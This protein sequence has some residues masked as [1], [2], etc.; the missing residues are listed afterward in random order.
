MKNKVI[1]LDSHASTPVD[2]DVLSEML[3]FFTQYYGNGNHKAG[4]KSAAAMEVA[5]NQVSNLIGARP[6]EV[7]FTSGATEAINMA[8]L[9]LAGANKTN[10]KHIITQRTEHAAVLECLDSL[11]E[12]GYRITLLDVDAVGRIDLNELQDV[13]DNETLVVAI[14]LANNEIGTVQPIEEI[15]KICHASGAKF[16]CDLTQG[17]GWHPIDVDKLNIDLAAMSAHKIYGP[18]GVGALFLRRINSKVTISPILFGGGQERGIRPGTANIPA[19]VGFGKACELLFFLSDHVYENVAF[20]RDRLKEFIFSAL[21][22]VQLN[23]CSSNRHPGNLNIS[24]PGITGEDLIGALPNII[25]STS[26]ACSSG[27]SKPSHV[28][29]ALGVSD[30]ISKGS[31]RL[32]INKFNTIDEI[33]Y[34][35]ERIVETV[36]R[37]QKRRIADVFI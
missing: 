4:W 31:F 33:D 24:I 12:K 9:G 21:E 1:Y 6:S 17:I 14:M 18:R 3:P 37:I 10:R 34:V 30:E 36:H 28:I 11:K 8:L 26:S 16:F 13:I 32:G 2:Q 27:S 23:G 5:R 20:L 25:F 19:I 7:I 22:G 29:S 15:G 35:G